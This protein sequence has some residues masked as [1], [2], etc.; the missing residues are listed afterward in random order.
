MADYMGFIKACENQFRRNFLGWFFVWVSLTSYFTLLKRVWWCTQYL[1]CNG[2]VLFE[3]VP[4]S[5]LG[6][7]ATQYRVKQP[8]A[9][10][11]R[12]LIATISGAIGAELL[13]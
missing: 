6:T 8:A 11:V 13:I 1:V 4:A 7:K 9:M 3:E 5:H 10:F 2:P 12:L